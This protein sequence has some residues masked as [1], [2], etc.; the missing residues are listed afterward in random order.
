MPTDAAPAQ[1]TLVAG[2]QQ[3]EVPLQGGAAQQFQLWSPMP[4]LQLSQQNDFLPETPS[5]GLVGESA[6]CP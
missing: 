1:N 6:R 3:E 4:V 5:R 2:V